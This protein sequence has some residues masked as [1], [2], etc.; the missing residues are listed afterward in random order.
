MAKNLLV[1]AV[2]FGG[3]AKGG[4]FAERAAGSPYDIGMSQ[5]LVKHLDPGSRGGRSKRCGPRI[6][7]GDGHVRGLSSGALTYFAQPAEKGVV[8]LL[9]SQVN[10]RGFDPSCEP[11]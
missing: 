2:E 1:L 5:I 3:F 9:F 6:V 8:L 7:Q 10:G 4:F 11:G